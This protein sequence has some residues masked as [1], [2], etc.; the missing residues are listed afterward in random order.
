MSYEGYEQCICKNGHYFECDCRQDLVCPICEEEQAWYNSVDETNYYSYGEIPLEVLRAK[1]LL[2]P[3]Q[4]KT[5]DLG[6]EHVVQE[7]IFRIPN[8]K[9]TNLLRHRRKGDG[10]TAPIPLYPK[11]VK[12]LLDSVSPREE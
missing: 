10:L 11:V 2:S 8:E 6:H 7:E 4:V 9:D 1:Y 5:C 3:A 12:D